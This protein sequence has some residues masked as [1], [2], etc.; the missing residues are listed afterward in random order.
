MNKRLPLGLLAILLIVLLA[1]VG[2]A[3]GLW[4]DT[5]YI[6]GTVHTGTLDIKFGDK[7]TTT[8]L[9]NGNPEDFWKGKGDAANC[10]AWVDKD[11]GNLEI[12]A[13]GAY[14]SWTCQVTFDVVS[15]GTVPVHVTWPKKIEGPKWDDLKILKCK[16]ISST[17]AEEELAVPTCT[18]EDS[19]K[20]TP[21]YVQLHTGDSLQCVLNI[22][23]VNKDNVTQDTTYKFVYQITG[24]QFNEYP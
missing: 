12:V 24:G 17:K 4:S 21:W 3:Y 5:L 13:K 10:G 19:T 18:D 2:V 16:K 20:C 6:N 14:P 8:E 23:F 15:V 1:G 22:H 11:T 7:P 9:I